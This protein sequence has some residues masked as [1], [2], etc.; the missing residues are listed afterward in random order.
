MNEKEVIV[1]F[2]KWMQKKDPQYAKIPTEHLVQQLNQILQTEE[3][4]AKL[5]PLID[6]FQKD[7]QG[8]M[9]KRGGKMD[10]AVKKMQPGGTSEK[11]KAPNNEIQDAADTR[12]FDKWDNRVEYDPYVYIKEDGVWVD[13][14]SPHP[15][16]KEQ[17]YALQREAYNKPSIRLQNQRRNYNAKQNVVVDEDGNTTYVLTTGFPRQNYNALEDPRSADSVITRKHGFNRGVEASNKDLGVSFYRNFPRV[18]EFFGYVPDF[19]K[20]KVMF[21]NNKK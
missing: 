6:E 4:F 16:S 19:E 2:A 14:S 18:A 7:V 12:L 20:W 21:E 8:G 11:V 17:Q 13:A 5:K 10:Q 1:A 9:F 15:I 3:G